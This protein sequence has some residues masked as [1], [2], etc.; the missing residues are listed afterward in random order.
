[1]TLHGLYLTL[2]LSPIIQAPTAQLRIASLRRKLVQALCRNPK[3]K[4]RHEV[5]DHKFYTTRT[6]S[7]Y[8]DFRQAGFGLCVPAAFGQLSEFCALLA[9]S[10]AVES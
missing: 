4:P 10:T 8:I 6:S 5:V 7:D 9:F 3:A 2:T 1:M